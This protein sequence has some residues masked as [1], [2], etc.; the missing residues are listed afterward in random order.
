MCSSDVSIPPFSSAVFSFV[1]M[2]VGT[3]VGGHESALPWIFM[4]TAGIFIYIALV[5]MMPELSSGHAHPYTDHAQHDSHL[6]E[7]ALQVCSLTLSL[8]L[9]LLDI[10]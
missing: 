3:L 1:G 8:L 2:L 7:M 6:K 10:H 5:D 9:P 4:A